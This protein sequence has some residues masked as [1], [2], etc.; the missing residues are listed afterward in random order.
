MQGCALVLESMGGYRPY[1]PENDDFGTI[2]GVLMPTDP[3]A[4]EEGRFEVGQGG[5]FYVRDLGATFNMGDYTNN[6]QIMGGPEPAQDW[7]GNPVTSYILRL[8]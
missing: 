4:I 8:A 6:A 2:S 1:D 7:E 3:I 5:Q